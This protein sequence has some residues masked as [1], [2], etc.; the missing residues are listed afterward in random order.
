MADAQ[1]L[2]QIEYRHH[3]TRDLSPVASSMSSPDSLRAWDSW[4]RAWVRHPHA[5]GLSESV[6]YQVLPNGQ[7][8]L[9]WRYWDQR[10]AE[11]ADGTRG[12][13]LVSRVLVG[14]A[15]VLTPE[16]AVVLC[17]AGLTADSVGPMPGEVPDGAELP[18][19]SRDALN[20]VTRMMTPVLDQDAAQQAGLQAL[21][22]A[23]LADPPTPLAI[24]VRDN[25]IQ[26]PLREGVQCP[27][28]WGLRRI[29]GPLL[30]PAG[31]GWSFSTFEPP[32]GE[33]DPASLPGI[34]FR[35][36]QEGVPAPPA[37]W[38]KEVK[39]HPLV[40]DALDPGFPYGG[41]VELAGWL[42]A[43]YQDRGGDGLEQFI[44][45]CCGSER[46]LPVRLERMHDEL[47]KT[48]SPVII[49][50][51]P[52]GFVSLTGGWASAPEEPESAGPD[53]EEPERGEPDRDLA[54]ADEG[55]RA[56]QAT[57]EL[58]PT[59]AETVI[60][61]SGDSVYH[62]HQESRRGGFQSAAR[63]DEWVKSLAPSREGQTAPQLPISGHSGQQAG[64]QGMAHP[65]ERYQS[66]R[67]SVTVSHLLKQLE[68]VGDDAGQFDSIMRGIFQAGRQSDDPNDRVKS[69]E[70]ISNIDWY[71]NI[72]KH[73]G[74]YLV[75]LTEIFGIV[76]IPELVGPAAAEA[77]ARWAYA[78]PPPM[79]GGLL[80]AAR[81]ASPEMWQDV[82]RILEPVLAARW[83]ADWSIQDQW[84]AG[85]VMRS[86]GELGRGEYTRG[87][88]GRFRRR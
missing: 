86:I 29:A 4:I 41:W 84:D 21:V 75:E 27:L 22:A 65:A 36:A 56:V 82:I 85:R 57:H 88:F 74:F 5:E 68:L 46:S 28:L 72:C 23:A 33:M 9:A 53:P 24:S 37:R 63:A 3:Q 54:G 47:R 49:S 15:S 70:V 44:A 69:W 12:R 76:V 45:E 51:E 6:C 62:E 42:V 52:T 80:A 73:R 79:I 58:A 39:V 17:R 35:Q 20:T 78:A 30:G 87:I 43:E 19:V 14:Q 31:R 59:R 61:G 48:K 81:K 66:P 83:V 64:A 34:V 40:S 1:D 77:I 10:A 16:V 2:H 26:K 67:Q 11:R 8:A 25:L 71:N 32:L 7:A 50:G 13:P 55:S 38:R 60:S 18:T